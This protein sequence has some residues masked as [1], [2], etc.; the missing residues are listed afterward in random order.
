[1]KE[2][3]VLGDLSKTKMAKVTRHLLEAVGKV[4]GSEQIQL[5]MCDYLVDWCQ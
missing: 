4:E 2:K 3:W 5:E 1:M